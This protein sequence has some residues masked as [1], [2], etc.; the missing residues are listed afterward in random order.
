MDGDICVDGSTEIA[1]GGGGQACVS[2]DEGMICDENNVCSIPPECTPEN[3][4]GCCFPSGICEQGRSTEACGSGAQRCETCEEEWTCENNACV[5]PPELC[6]PGNCEGCCDREGVCQTGDGTTFCGLSGSV[7]Q[8][9]EESESCLEGMCS[10]AN[11]CA[12][13][14]AGCCVGETCIEATTNQQCGIDGATCNDCGTQTCVGGGCQVPSIYDI[15]IVSTIVAPTK[16]DGSSWDALDDTPEQYVLAG[17]IDPVIANKE[18]SAG[19]S[20]VSALNVSWNTVL[21]T[22]MPLAALQNRF[23]IEMWEGDTFSDDDVI[24]AFDNILVDPNVLA[25]NTVTSICAED[26]RTSI[27]WRLVAQ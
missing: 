10:D 13:S 1:C 14:C 25:G 27:M 19:T 4:Q 21:D 3:C 18:Y 17:A 16:P 5:P 22:N 12:A 11:S 26:G 23:I 7:C 6:G 20:E 9:C 2:C 15:E 8:A 24:C